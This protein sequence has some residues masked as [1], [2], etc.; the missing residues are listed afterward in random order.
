MDSTTQPTKKAVGIFNEERGFA[1]G[2]W[3]DSG[4]IVDPPLDTNWYEDN[5]GASLEVHANLLVDV[6]RAIAS[7]RTSTTTSG[8]TRGTSVSCAPRTVRAHTKETRR[9]A[10]ADCVLHPAA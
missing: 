2:N 3:C 7:E 9:R 4:D 10:R 1:A 5:Q 8:A 6:C